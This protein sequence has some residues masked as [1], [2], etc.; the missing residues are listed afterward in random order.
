MP[1]GTW[2]VVVCGRI[3]EAREEIYSLG[4]RYLVEIIPTAS[5]FGLR[6]GPPKTWP[7]PLSDMLTWRLIAIPAGKVYIPT[8]Y[9]PRAVVHVRRLGVERT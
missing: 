7:G 8:A 9:L 5:L 6:L 1:D 2:E 3:R 4:G